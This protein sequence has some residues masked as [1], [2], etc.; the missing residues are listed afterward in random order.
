MV[1]IG[2]IFVTDIAHAFREFVLSKPSVYTRKTYNSKLNGFIKQY[3]DREIGSITAEEVLEWFDYRTRDLNEATKAMIR[4]K[5]QAFLNVCRPG[6]N[7]TRLIPRYSD[8]PGVIILP[9][10]SLV[11]RAVQVA[12]GLSRSDDVIDRRD[13]LIFMLAFSTGVRTGEMIAMRLSAMTSALRSPEVDPDLGQIYLVSTT[14]KT[15]RRLVP[16]TEMLANY[17]RSYLELRPKTRHD[18]L[19]VGLNGRHTGQPLRAVGFAS[20]RRRIARAAGGGSFTFQELRRRKATVVSKKYGLHV[21]AMV[22]GHS[23]STGTK[24]VAHHYT[25]VYR[26][27]AA[28]MSVRSFLDEMAD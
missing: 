21:A 15:G 27:V 23:E 24:V 11:K 5:L 1:Y 16:L 8:R 14:G 18:F 20:S 6:E 26:E 9:D 13:A 25:D 28:R 2:G 3:G 22:L 10:E 19:F 17:A 4:S 12:A 7:L